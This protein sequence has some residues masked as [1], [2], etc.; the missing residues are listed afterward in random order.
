[1]DDIHA[2]HGSR[3]IVKHPLRRIAEIHLEP[4]I[5]IL[6]NQLLEKSRDDSGG[7]VRFGT[8][9]LERRLNTFVQGFRGEAVESVLEYQLTSLRIEI[10]SARGAFRRYAGIT[11][12]IE[13]I[14]G[15]DSR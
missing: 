2:A 13:V 4:S 12:E 1:M 15:R 5:G 9:L 14:Q 3:S 8:M 10:R 11:R 7:I 6:G